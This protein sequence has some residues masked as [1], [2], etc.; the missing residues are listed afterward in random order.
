MSSDI[1]RLT[2]KAYLPE[3]PKSLDSILSIKAPFCEARQMEAL[4]PNKGVILKT[5]VGIDVSKEKLDIAMLF[6]GNIIARGEFVNDKSGVRTLLKWAKKKLKHGSE[7]VFGCEATGI[8][9][10][11]CA[12]IIFNGKQKFV[13]INPRFIKHELEAMGRKNKTDKVDAEVIAIR[14]SREI[15]RLWTP[16]SDA[17]RLLQ[18]L[19]LRREQLS[20]AI[21]SE[22]NRRDRFPNGTARKSVETIIKALQQEL[23]EIEC[24]MDEVVDSDDDLKE[25]VEL[26]DSVP[27]VG[28]V[29][30]KAFI[31]AIG[32]IDNFADA[33]QALSFLGTCPRQRISGTSL[34]KSWMSK[35]G[36]HILRKLLYMGAMATAT[37]SKNS[38]YK[39][40]YESLVARGKSKR[41]AIAAVMRK[42]VR[43]MFAVVRDR[44]PFSN[45]RYAIPPWRLK[46]C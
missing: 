22:M 6:D 2:E 32:D 10:L 9:H 24:R 17:V 29:I 16:P 19:L 30:A 7:P 18:D 33:E 13:V 34:N 40:Y 1:K 27:G 39:K 31:A 28:P 12:Q 14:L 41:A 26:A 44:E 15:D 5:Y 37:K 11:N 42:I 43:A 45:Q 23:D 25:Q 8:Y 46:T 20:R 36:N 21:V 4:T 3:L 35:Q 38:V